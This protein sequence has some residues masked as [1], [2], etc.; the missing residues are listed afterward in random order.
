MPKILGLIRQN[1]SKFKKAPI[2]PLGAHIKLGQKKVQLNG[3]EVTVDLPVEAI[4]KGLLS[5]FWCD[6]YQD[7]KT[8]QGLLNSSRLQ[9]V[10]TIVQPFRDQV[11][12]GLQ[13][14]SQS[15]AYVRLMDT[16]Q[17]EPVGV[18]NVLVDQAHI[19]GVV[20]VQEK[21]IGGA[22]YL[23][24]QRNVRRIFAE[25]GSQKVKTA[26]GGGVRGIGAQKMQAL[27]LGEDRKGAMR[28]L[29]HNLQ[30]VKQDQD[31]VRAELQQK[32]DVFRPIE[33]EEK[34]ML[35]ELQGL[36]DQKR[37]LEVAIKELNDSIVGT[38]LQSDHGL[39]DKRLSLLKSLSEKRELLEQA[40]ARL[41]EHER[42]VAEAKHV[43]EGA[44]RRK[45]EKEDEFEI[46]KEKQKKLVA[47]L[48][49]LKVS[50]VPARK[51]LASGEKKLVD[52]R[53]ELEAKEKG[54]TEGIAAAET[55]FA[56]VPVT[57]SVAQ[58]TREVTSMELALARQQEDQGKTLQEIEADYLTLRKKYKKVKKSI[59][60]TETMLLELS[61]ALTKRQKKIDRIT[62]K[63]GTLVST[64]F[65][66][67]LT[68]KGY[69]GQAR[70]MHEDGNGQLDIS[71][72]LNP[73]SQSQ[74]SQDVLTLSGGESSFTTVALLLALWQI[75]DPP[76]R[77]MDEFDIFM[78]AV[79]RKLS[80]VTLIEFA[81]SMSS[82][83]FI[84]LS[85]LDSKVIPKGAD[86]T[87]TKL[88]APRRAGD[89]RN[90]FE[91]AAN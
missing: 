67:Y 74:S 61:V 55:V 17:C 23:L 62:A 44:D 35:K 40:D 54:V 1:R 46:E 7:S 80:I 88:E 70:F 30:R 60:F 19:E 2:G 26:G 63:Y 84:F 59:E 14:P 57:K 4:L 73:A 36:Q 48:K 81:R 31:S 83:Q 56:R 53:E 43:M 51:K 22:D 6:N 58:L 11:Y 78:D 13:L 32:Q 28:S 68:K 86:I 16:I 20:I 82:K 52:I 15:D 42:K 72:N 89:I 39:E 79:H 75:I 71:V 33:A 12:E 29:H 45:E 87:V 18:W 8:L 37:K 27:T 10:R 34:K 24:D 50:L 41:A 77:I 5:C 65:N 21:H 47:R 25:D 85:P 91:N 38:D 9:Q 64:W 76:F 69:E 90:A 49:K 3:E 66:G